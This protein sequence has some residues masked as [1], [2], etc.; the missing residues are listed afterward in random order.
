M[1]VA[2]FLGEMAG[3][4]GALL[5]PMV[6]WYLGVRASQKGDEQKARGWKTVAVGFLVLWIVSYFG[7]R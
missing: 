7:G 5:L 6:F 1:G 3:A 2:D 4:G